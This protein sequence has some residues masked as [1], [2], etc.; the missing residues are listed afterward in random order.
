MFDGWFQ[1]YDAFVE[2]Q[3]EVAS[4][5]Q[6]LQQFQSNCSLPVL[7]TG[8]IMKLEFEFCAM[9]K[10][11]SG[12]ITLDD[13]TFGLG[14]SRDV[15]MSTFDKY[16]LS[17]DGLIDRDEFLLMMCP[18]GYRMPDTNGEGRD[19]LGAILGAHARALK[20]QLSS[21]K[22]SFDTKGC[23]SQMEMIS[24]MPE[25]LR[26]EVDDATWGAW[27]KVFDDLDTDND[28][29]VTVP[30]LRS[31][32]LLTFDICDFL[33]SHV[34]GSS[35]NGFSRRAYLNALLQATGQRRSG[36]F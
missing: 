23:V 33:G 4:S 11:N 10:Q 24:E 12:Y 19:V 26:P 36:F 32:R 28:G 25:S 30:E 2:Q 14:I 5:E 27:N 35:E 17:D 6:A 7:S 31:S 18:D 34:D 16:D 3:Q 20:K 13:M 22:A 9:D 29:V 15:V 8:E 1:K 21:D